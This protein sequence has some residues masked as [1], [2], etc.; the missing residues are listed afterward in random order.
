MVTSAE[1]LPPAVY[2]LFSKVA[3]SFPP[4][5]LN[6]RDGWASP[7]L[8]SN[9]VRKQGLLPL[10]PGPQPITGR[11]LGPVFK[12]RATK[13]ST[14]P[15]P[16]RFPPQ[17]RRGFVMSRLPYQ[18]QATMWVRSLQSRR[19]PKAPGHDPT[20][21]HHRSTF[22][23]RGLDSEEG[24]GQREAIPRGQDGWHESARK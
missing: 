7:L 19:V 12:S 4:S 14:L 5:L 24:A 10:I 13:V 3:G 2:E 11:K 9:T 15:A 23:V 8:S 21:R 20:G 17:D 18:G 16:A 6:F 22:G 1:T